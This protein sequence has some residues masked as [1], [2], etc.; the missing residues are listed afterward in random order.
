MKFL[1][2]ME[3]L[4]DIGV[5]PVNK[6]ILYSQYCDLKRPDDKVSELERKGLI[7][8]VKRDLY[9]VSQKVHNQEISREQIEKTN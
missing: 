9:I 1:E 4:K 8:R 6:D 5:I 2:E 7:I 3:R